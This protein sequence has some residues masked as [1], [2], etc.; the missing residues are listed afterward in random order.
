MSLM[1]KLCLLTIVFTNN[2]AMFE[3]YDS[4]VLF[5]IRDC[6]IILSHISIISLLKDKESLSYT[7]Q[8]C[9]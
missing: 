4:L 6:F 7:E 2:S 9:K 3:T 1:V 5:L 8:N